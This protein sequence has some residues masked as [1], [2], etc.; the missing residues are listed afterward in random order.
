MGFKSRYDETNL[1]ISVKKEDLLVILKRN[2]EQHKKDFDRAIYFWQKRF[3][4][5]LE[6]VS[7][8]TYT[9]FPKSLERVRNSCPDSCVKEYDDI[10]DM[11]EMSIND[12]IILTSDAYRKFCKDEWDWKSS[13]YGN[14]YYTNLAYLEQE[15]MTE[16]EEE[17]DS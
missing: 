8:E 15:E 12:T 9:V 7:E 13:T 11:F 17:S 1:E 2:R 10:I 14:W 5:V 6:E 16:T 3:K 4:E